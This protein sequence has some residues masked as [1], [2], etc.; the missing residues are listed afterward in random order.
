MTKP[1]IDISAL[2]DVLKTFSTKAAQASATAKPE[3]T[4]WWYTYTYPDAGEVNVKDFLSFTKKALFFQALSGGDKIQ[5]YNT[6]KGF[7][8][9]KDKLITQL[10][11]DGFARVVYESSNTAYDEYAEWFLIKTNAGIYIKVYN[12]GNSNVSMDIAMVTTDKHDIDRVIAEL[13]VL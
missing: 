12:F 8:G 2:T 3:K 5:E 7:T 13:K 6:R 4:P 11:K 1:Q 9:N 10:T